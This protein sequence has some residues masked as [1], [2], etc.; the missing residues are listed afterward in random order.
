LSFPRKR[1]PDGY[2]LDCRVKPDNDNELGALTGMI[3]LLELAAY[4]VGAEA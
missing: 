4:L 3:T 1:N 2:F